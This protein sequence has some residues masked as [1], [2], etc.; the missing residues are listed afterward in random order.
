MEYI[1]GGTLKSLVTKH[2]Q[3]KTEFSDREIAQIIKSILEGIKY[4]HKF[5]IIHRDLKLG[6]YYNYHGR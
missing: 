2:H 3:S 4:L 5:N 1:A 6:M